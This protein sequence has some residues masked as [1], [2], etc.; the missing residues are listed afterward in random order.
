MVGIVGHSTTPRVSVARVE[1]GELRVFQMVSFGSSLAGAGGRAADRGMLQLKNDYL[2]LSNSTLLQ[3]YAYDHPS[4]TLL[5]R[6]STPLT[7][8]VCTLPRTPST[9]SA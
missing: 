4:Q 3:L 1:A 8:Q 5:P 6:F 7:S 2:M 9:S